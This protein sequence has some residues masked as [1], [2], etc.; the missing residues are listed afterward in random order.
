MNTKISAKSAAKLIEKFIT[1]DTLNNLHHTEKVEAIKAVM[2]GVDPKTVAY[3][4][5]DHEVFS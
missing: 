3:L 5:E 1:Q 4:M 2:R